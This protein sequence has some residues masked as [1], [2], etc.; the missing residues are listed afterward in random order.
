MN[1]RFQRIFN[2][3][4]INIENRMAQM[5]E[6]W[7]QNGTVQSTGRRGLPEDSER[8]E[9]L[10]SGTNQSKQEDSPVNGADNQDT[11]SPDELR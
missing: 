1:P 4:S 2:I 5:Q 8:Q 6:K 11:E 9:S 7:S 10:D 3:A